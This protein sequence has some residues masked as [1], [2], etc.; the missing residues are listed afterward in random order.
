MTDAMGHGVASA[1]T[2]TLCVGSLRNFRRHGLSLPDQA[3]AAN[4]ALVTHQA[5]LSAEAYCTGLLGR[6]HLP[7]GV[8]EL[9][10]AGHAAPYLLRGGAVR[11]LDLPPAAPFGLLPDTDYTGTTVALRPGDRLVVVTD[12][13][14]ERN[15]E[16]LDLPAVIA[17]TAHLHAREATRALTDLVLEATGQ[18]LADDA[19]LL[20]L[21]WH[22]GHGRGRSTHAGTP[23]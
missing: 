13:M 11:T 2:A 6:L 20:I 19:T 14:L 15:A 7:T 10:N 9:V 22:G 5:S 12:G 16:H 23:A 3:R 18:A 1:L 4:D 21:D 17:A 8:L